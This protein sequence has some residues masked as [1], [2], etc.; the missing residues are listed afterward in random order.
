MTNEQAVSRR[1]IVCG[2]AASL[3]L[4]GFAPGAG[5]GESSCFESDPSRHGLMRGDVDGDGNRDAVW[6]IARRRSGRCRYFV[7]ADLGDS[8]DRKRIR[9]SRFALRNYSRVMAMIKVDTVSGKE[10]GVVL[11]QGASTTLAGLFTIRANT[12]RRMNVHGTGAP[13]DDLFAYGGGISFQFA[14]DCARRRPAGQVIYT[15]AVYDEGSNRYKV[16]RKWFQVVGIDFHR[17]AEPT[18][19][20]R[21][22]P[23]RLHE[24]FYEFRNNPFGSCPG[25]A[26]G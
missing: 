7:K 17:T 8:T 18:Q 16:R 26:P 2:L 4:T 21:V 10:F 6:I 23:G 11:E 24:R 12:I 14:V 15:E 3:L 22:R 20:E 9:G 19:R 13:P 5:A 1:M 25:R